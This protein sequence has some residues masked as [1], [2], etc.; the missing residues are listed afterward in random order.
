LNNLGRRGFPSG[1]APAQGTSLRT[2]FWRRD[3]LLAL[4][5]YFFL[6]LSVALFYIYPLYFERLGAARSRVGLI[7][8]VHS[9]LAILVRPIFGRLIDARGGRRISLAGI[10][11]FMA[12]VP[13]FHFVRDAGFLPLGLRALTGIAWGVSMTATMAICSE[14]APV[15]RLARSIGVIG[16]AGIVASAIGPAAA[17]EV[18]RRFGFGGLF[19]T[20]LVFLA[21]S[22]ILMLLTR[23]IPRPERDAVPM[24]V[25]D[26]R[27]RTWTVLLIIAAMP[28]FH[29]AVRGSVVNFIALFGK[30]LGFGRVGPFFFVFSVAAVLTRLGVGDLSDRYGRKAVILPAAALIS[31]NLFW[32]AGVRSLPM[33]LVNGFI[34]GLGQGLIFP[35]LSTYIID[36]LGREHK[37]FA[38]SLYMA[39]YDTGVGLGSPFF[40][41][42][43]DRAG[44]RTMYLVAGALLLA[45]TIVFTIKAPKPRLSDTIAVSRGEQR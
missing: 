20:S 15:D 6:F 36:L 19:N 43:S 2:S 38:L 16:V 40:G 35:A 17:E 30:S 1:S 34:A 21:T 14:L 8:G 24:R 10:L 12:V 27:G 31:L 29:G 4:G 28:V 11:F 37:G 39:L 13:L 25:K 42:V 7:M 9:L 33:F 5:S 45:S 18:V 3:F 44:Y 41:W 23:E 32:I 22:L 26:L